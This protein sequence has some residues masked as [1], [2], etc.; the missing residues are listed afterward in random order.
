[1]NNGCIKILAVGDV[2]GVGG[3][4]YI[5]EKL[6]GI[7]KRLC[8]DMV[9]LNGENAA[10]GNGIDPDT[11]ETLFSSGADVITSGNHIWQKRSVQSYIESNVCLLRPVN[12]PPSCPG[13]GYVIFDCSGYRVLVISVMG[14]V[15]LDALESPFTAVDRVL[16]R[17][18]GSYDFAFCDIHAEATKRKDCVRQI[19]RRQN[20]GNRRYSHARSDS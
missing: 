2:V 1:M 4:A 14:T 20:F 10:P 15:F 11:A 9:I 19:F 5:K 13:N 12:Y 6:W 3:T 7:R 17:E 16:E 8:A 18:K